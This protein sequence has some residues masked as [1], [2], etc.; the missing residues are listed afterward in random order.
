[1]T[2]RIAEYTN[3]QNPVCSRDIRS[4]DFV[5]QKLEKELFA[6]GYYYERKKSQF[7]HHNKGQR[8]D[9]EKTGQILLSFL[10]K[11]P[12]EA[13]NQKSEIFASRY[14]E[15]F[16]DSINADK[17]LL[18]IKLFERIENSKNSF[19][20][21]LIN[22]IDEDQKSSYLSYAS[23]WL[24]F[25]LSELAIRKNIQFEESQLETIWSLY[26][27]VQLLIENLIQKEKYVMAKKN[28]KYSHV[29]FFKH[30]R[31]KKLYEDM[32]NDEIAS[33]LDI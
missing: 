5:Q 30:N 3:S 24:L 1:L 14:E 32:T 33:F 20:E 12:S 11:M 7:S 22:G 17:V 9:A 13:K 26:S 15:I 28:D 29:A 8:I 4:I 27:N 16:N 23:Y 10:N 19:K 18:G 31:P 21:K 25:F 6:K 2:T